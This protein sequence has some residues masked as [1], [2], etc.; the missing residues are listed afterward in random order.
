MPTLNTHPPLYSWSP[1]VRLMINDRV[2]IVTDKS[3]MVSSSGDRRL[4]TLVAEDNGETMEELSDQRYQAA[5]PKKEPPAPEDPPKPTV[6]PVAVTKETLTPT[7]E[8]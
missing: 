5:P 1:G 4:I 7:S 2:W 8:K 6:V 3:R